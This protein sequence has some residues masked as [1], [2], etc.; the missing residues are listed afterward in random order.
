MRKDK[1]LVSLLP[2]QAMT[3]VTVPIKDSNAH[4]TSAAPAQ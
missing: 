2:F 1:G 3:D 4:S